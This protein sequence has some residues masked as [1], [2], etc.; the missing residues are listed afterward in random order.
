MAE[1]RYTMET[2]YDLFVSYADA[3]RAWVEGY[4]L[5]ALSSANLRV[6]SELNFALGAPRLTEFERALQQSTRTL[7]ILSP[8]YVAEAMLTFVELIG[9]HYG[10]EVGTWPVI[11]LVLAPVELPPRLAMLVALDAT[12]SA[13][14]PV[15]VARLCS[16]LQA[17]S[18]AAPTHPPCPYPGMRAFRNNEAHAF[19]G[20]DAEIEELVQRLRHYPFATVIGASGSGKSSLVI[21]GL[22]PALQRSTLF[23]EGDWLVRTLRPGATPLDELERALGGTPLS[24]FT[25]PPLLATAA[26]ATRLL[27]IVDQFEEIFTQ[28]AAQRDQFFH[29]L[30]QL[31]TV[32][33]CFVV[34]TVRSDFFSDLLN[35]TLW[36]I[37]RDHRL[38]IAPL[39]KAGLR[40]AIVKPAEALHV[41]I[42]S[43]LVERLVAGSAGEPGLLPF[44]QEVLVRLWEKLERRYLPLRAYETLVLPLSRYSGSERSGI[45]AAMGLLAD[46][47]IHGLTP[48]QQ[49]IARRIFLR[50]V[51]FG[52]GRADTRRQQ[53]LSHL[54]AAGDEPSQFEQTLHYLSN[55]RL[56][57]L[58][59]AEG[60]EARVD[61]AHEAM[62]TG[63]PMLQ[64][65]LMEGKTVEIRRRQLE[66]RATQ[67]TKLGRNK[68]DYFDAP[69]LK[70]V[71]QWLA[72]STIL[73]LGC[74]VDLQVLIRYSRQS[75]VRKTRITLAKY[76]L[77]FLVLSLIVG[78]IG[79][80]R[81]LNR[82][83]APVA[84]LPQ[85]SINTLAMGTNEVA[86]GSLG[87]G[88]AR[89]PANVWQSWQADDQWRGESGKGFDPAEANIDTILA[90]AYDYQRQDQLYAWVE[91]EGIFHSTG[92]TT[93]W[94]LLPG[95]QPLQ[96]TGTHP[97]AVTNGTVLA[98]GD[99]LGIHLWQEGE[100]TWQHLTTAELNQEFEAIV[101]GTDGLP[102]LAGQR[103]II[104][105]TA[106][107]PWQWV[108]LIKL[109][110]ARLVAVDADHTIYV[111]SN[112]DAGA[113]VACFDAT[114]A[115]IGS[116]QH[117][118]VTNW[119]LQLLG[120]VI[121]P[122]TVTAQA[123]ALVVNPA[124]VHQFFVATN[125]G[126]VFAMSCDGKRSYLGQ[127][128]FIQAASSQLALVEREGRSLLL[129][130]TLAGL[131][132]RPVE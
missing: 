120:R 25:L 97:L 54:R 36:P 66:E 13:L 108:E 33:A 121:R 68:H 92:I 67:W 7:L 107:A 49:Q 122:L 75:I 84:D 73:G 98:I 111:S 20:R 30:Q 16:T 112:N 82:T 58:S 64:G 59:G 80:L 125:Q 104:R 128:N 26:N 116:P 100:V 38:E 95:K 113:Q 96:T 11:P 21:A 17:T 77:A 55:H 46:E 119:L 78:N 34:L 4:L 110:G 72:A 87:F 45:Q 127:I 69:Q 63:W 129:W 109:P 57:V 5:D 3:D 1:P 40:A 28:G 47:I 8:A 126:A 86:V 114:G 52:E 74:T 71:E 19:F 15:M 91:G 99:D 102:Y 42:E 105:G 132:Q 60:S 32:P 81:W 41:Y 9:Q 39:G 29:A 83:W 2:A 6:I 101:T 70:E 124:R 24:N 31:V 53:S 10:L 118:P 12:D 37:L 131:Q 117:V 65:W 130:G 14:W 85:A 62:I 76:L 93:S 89:A 22:I 106:V 23:G 43:A 51:Q 50:L 79:Y 115:P 90:L 94:T 27:L 123:T 103:G 44:V 56:L 48:P 35:S 61:L 88:V 18:P